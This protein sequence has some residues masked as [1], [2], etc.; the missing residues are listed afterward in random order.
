MKIT[1]RGYFPIDWGKVKQLL[2][3]QK[4]NFEVIVHMKA[5]PRQVLGEIKLSVGNVPLKPIEASI[6]KI[7]N[8]KVEGQTIPLEEAKPVKV[9]PAM[10]LLE[11][12]KVGFESI[13]EEL[14]IMPD[15]EPLVIRRKLEALKVPIQFEVDSDYNPGKPARPYDILMEDKEIESDV[16]LTPGRYN[17]SLKKSGFHSINRSIKIVP[18]TEPYIF[19]GRFKAKE[20]RLG[21]DIRGGEGLGKLDIIRNEVEV[22]LNNNKLS[23]DREIRM[24]P[25]KNCVFKIKAKGFALWKKN[26]DIEPSDEDFVIRA[27]LST[28]KRRV[29]INVVST[30]PVDKNL[31]PV[32]KAL[33]SGPKGEERVE[34]SK[35]MLVAEVK[36]G[37]YKLQIEKS[38]YHSD[39]RKLDI[40]PDEAVYKVYVRLTPKPRPVDITVEREIPS[41]T[42]VDSIVWFMKTDGSTRTKVTK[43]QEVQPDNYDIEIEAPGYHKQR[44]RIK[45]SPSD[46]GFFKTYTL[47]P[48]IRDIEIRAEADYPPQKQLRLRRVIL[49]GKELKVVGDVVYGKVLPKKHSILLEAD[50]YHQISKEFDVLASTKE[51]RLTQRLTAKARIVTYKI[52]DSETKRDLVPDKITLNKIPVTGNKAF[53]PKKYQLEVELEGYRPLVQSVDIHPGEGPHQLNL[54]LVPTSRIVEYEVKG[55]YTTKELVPKQITLNGK[56]VDNKTSFAPGNYKLVIYVPGYKRL[57]STVVITPSRDVFKINKNLVSK[58]RKVN[59]NVIA[60]YPADVKL[61]P[62]KVMFNDRNLIDGEEVKPIVGG[63]QVVVERE[64]YLPYSSNVVIE[65][66]EETYAL[67]V[68]LKTRPRR[69]EPYL[70]SDFR[71]NQP[72][73]A[74]NI[75]FNGKPLSKTRQVE[76]GKYKVS[77]S[78]K[79]YETLEFAAN[80]EPA[81]NA[82]VI[83]KTFVSKPRH[84]AAVIKNDYNRE[85]EMKELDLLQLGERNI[86]PEEM[87]KPGTYEF[88][89]KH[90]GYQEIRHKV[91]V[92]PGVGAHTI[93][94]TLISKNRRVVDKITFDIPAPPSLEAH[95]V[96]LKKIQGTEGAFRLQNG[97]SIKPGEYFVTIEKEAYETVHRRVAIAPSEK[98]YEIAQELSAKLRQVVLRID[99]NLP[100]PKGIK[101]YTVT[102]IHKTSGIGQLV[103]DG[104]SIKPGEY[105][106]EI[107]QPAYK[108]KA[109]RKNVKIE[110]STKPF[111][112]RET[113]I[114][115]KRRLS[116]EMVEKGTTL[117]K[118]M[119]ILINEQP[120]EPT[121]SFL[122]GTK[123]SFRA[124]FE[125][126]KTVQKDV[127]IPPGEKSYVVD[128]K[129]VQL[130]KYDFL[131]SKKF[132]ERRVD[133]M[134]VG[135]EIYAD[136]KEIEP[137]HIK[138]EKEG[139]SMFPGY[140]YG[141]KST[142]LVRVVSGY[143]YD[144]SL[145]KRIMKFRDLKKID[146]N[147][148]VEH[149]KEIEKTRSPLRALR[150]I[151]PLMTRKRIRK[152]LMRLP[153]EDREKIANALRQLKL[154]QTHQKKR[155]EYVRALLK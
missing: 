36:P 19:Q 139:V 23:L 72:I 58:P 93:Q 66:A 8:G 39:T 1:K 51:F 102:F 123:Y 134:R 10:Y 142:R 24:L 104:K 41:E 59:F 153:R 103:T 151:Q 145:R 55:D 137:H 16:K 115:K 62:E 11:I 76:P 21:F 116:F 77:L 46:K 131:L 125:K 60:N 12:K 94:K 27:V 34:G 138:V 69:V 42:K 96:R 150:S 25:Q 63:Y 30:F 71:P 101:H 37:I 100:V 128:V 129:L 132:V 56:L 114:A 118:A 75:T 47:Q 26:V 154:P 124:K 15:E 88:V 135:L 44:G 68:K 106:L 64:G 3:K 148:L 146:P 73:E 5:K 82:Y 57:V 119:E 2:H 85:E 108:F 17:L 40:Q 84:V 6:K 127:T 20:R 89:A 97:D 107:S 143:D 78:R 32:D 111:F 35:D 33:L 140:F 52:K 86:T 99:H 109:S 117:V 149:I 67:N 83:K 49:D 14:A 90:S 110:P 53:K 28:L 105:F 95:V 133:G 87:F 18:G 155:N 54:S 80:V 92:P 122:P 91:Q 147:R 7:R 43:G 141:P 65:P 70:D 126:H 9:H 130:K 136:G 4:R 120:I 45:L 48:K 38:A 74:E 152:K 113:L 144:E 29:L 31:L 121:D 61:K 98:D 50:G 22:T 81:N 79:G 13:R 112:I